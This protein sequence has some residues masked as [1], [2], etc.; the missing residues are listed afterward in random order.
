[1]RAVD[2]DSK[3]FQ[4]KSE[5]MLSL[6]VIDKADIGKPNSKTSNKSL[7]GI[8]KLAKTVAAAAALAS[9]LPGIIVGSKL[10]TKIVFYFPI[11]GNL[12][13]PILK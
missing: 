5:G 13:F 11:L 1:M 7:P 3:Y 6:E 4:T 2:E 12:I 9:L 10:I 8:N